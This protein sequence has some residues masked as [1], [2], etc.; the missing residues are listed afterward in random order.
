MKDPVPTRAASCPWSATRAPSLDRCRVRPCSL[1]CV[2]SEQHG[3]LGPRNPPGTSPSTFPLSEVLPSQPRHHQ[4]RSS[5][6]TQY[7][8][9][10]NPRR[11]A[12]RH[13][14]AARDR[15]S[16][17]TSI[18]AADGERHTNSAIPRRS[19]PREIASAGDQR[20]HPRFHHPRWANAKNGGIPG[21]AP[22]KTP[23]TATPATPGPTRP[24]PLH[25]PQ[26]CFR[27][28]GQALWQKIAAGHSD[29]GP[30]RSGF[31]SFQISHRPPTTPGY[32]NISSPGIDG[33]QAGSS[34]PRA[35]RTSSFTSVRVRRRAAAENTTIKLLC[36]WPPSPP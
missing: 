30:M 32:A 7:G 14:P 22:T 26:T 5:C 36:C 28:P 3:D 34:R 15:V 2:S 12:A 20:P 16:S 4:L 11:H 35:P 24:S 18:V 8:L 21:G 17:A 13:S 25:R 9:A 33:S 1:P 31:K 23:D 19:E 6:P 10:P 27:S 29:G